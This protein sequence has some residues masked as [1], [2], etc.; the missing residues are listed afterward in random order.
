M[1]KQQNTKDEENIR[2]HN[3]FCAATE[4][5][6]SSNANVLDFHREY[7]L[8]KEPIK[9]D[10][11][12]VRVKDTVVL[13][14]E[15]AK[16]FFRGHNVIE[17]KSPGDEV[18]IDTLYKVIAY[19]ALYKAETGKYVDA[20][21]DTDITM[22]I[23]RE[24]KP[25]KLLGSL[26]K[27]GCKITGRCKGIYEVRNLLFPLQIIVTKEL[28]EK[29]HIWL[30]S[31]TRNISEQNARNLAYEY[32]AV[33][34]SGAKN[35]L[36]NAETV[37]NLVSHASNVVLTG[38]L[39]EEGIMTIM[40]LAAPAIEAERKKTDEERKKTD[41]ERKKT[42]N[43]RRTGIRN[44]AELCFRFNQPRE[45]AKEAIIEKYP[46]SSSSFI[47]SILAEYYD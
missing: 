13:D 9:I 6:L 41:E 42:K 18:N 19:A 43:E 31:L 14:N 26:K 3:A 39:K 10:M 8:G 20:V 28:D 40:E 36:L 5:E 1:G 22:T 34:E 25:L 29:N 16:D 21:K 11:L 2:W 23:M 33:R 15:I 27:R 7:I 46:D 17:Y 37:V 45:T 12:V 32:R 38:E 30:K 4:L 35:D 24:G 44:M 47:D